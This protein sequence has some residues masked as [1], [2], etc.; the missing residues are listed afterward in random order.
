MLLAASGNCH[1]TRDID[2]SGIDVNNDAATVLNLVRPV[3]TSRLPDDDVL[4]Y[5]ADSATA[6]VTSKEDNYSGVQVTATTTLAS[7]RLTFHVD[8]SVGYPIYPPVPTIRK[9]S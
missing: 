7:A 4:I 9:P 5:Q 3:F 8:V 2:L 6:E 1:P